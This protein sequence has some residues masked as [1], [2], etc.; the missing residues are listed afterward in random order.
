MIL[1]SYVSAIS[2]QRHN[3]VC[4]VYGLLL[5]VNRKPLVFLDEQHLISAEIVTSKITLMSLFQWREESYYSQI[6][7]RHVTI[8]LE[9]HIQP[10]SQ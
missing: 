2:N 10:N 7:L 6:N 3:P 5:L 1:F 9:Y 4:S 8:K